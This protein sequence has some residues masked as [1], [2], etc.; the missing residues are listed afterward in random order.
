M[1]RALENQG[2]SPNLLLKDLNFSKFLKKS[3]KSQNH[4]IIK[5]TLVKLF[6]EI[7]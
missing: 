3:E 5:M 7:H 2:K 4:L 6:R 1:G